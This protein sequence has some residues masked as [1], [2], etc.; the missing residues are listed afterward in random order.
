[1]ANLFETYK[2][3]KW[4]GYVGHRSLPVDYAATRATVDLK[5]YS[6]ITTICL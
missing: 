6:R 2:A 1:M 5:L 4:L 3:T